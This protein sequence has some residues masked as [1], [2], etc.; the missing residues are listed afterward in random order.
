MSRDKIKQDYTHHQSFLRQSGPS[1]AETPRKLP[2]NTNSGGIITC[3][4]PQGVGAIDFDSVF[5]C[6]S[7]QALDYLSDVAR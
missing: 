1:R 3:F 6:H 5:L 4:S 2:L 7:Q